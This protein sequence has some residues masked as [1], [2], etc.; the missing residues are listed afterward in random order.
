MDEC[1]HELLLPFRYGMPRG[2]HQAN[3]FDCGNFTVYFIRRWFGSDRPDLSENTTNLKKWFS[4]HDIFNFKYDCRRYLDKLV[5]LADREPVNV[6]GN[7]E[8]NGYFEDFDTALE[9]WERNKAYRKNKSAATH[10]TSY[11]ESQTKS[12]REKINLTSSTTSNVLMPKANQNAES[13]DSVTQ[14]PAA[15]MI[16]Q[17]PKN[18]MKSPPLISKNSCDTTPEVSPFSRES[19]FLTGPI[20]NNQHEDDLYISYPV[21]DKNPA[22][23][24]STRLVTVSSKV[25]KKSTSEKF[26]MKSREKIEVTSG[27]SDKSFK[28]DNIT[29]NIVTYEELDKAIK[30]VNTAS[31]IFIPTKNYQEQ[32]SELFSSFERK[33]FCDKNS[34]NTCVS[35]KFKRSRNARNFKSSKY[36]II[37]TATFLSRN[38]LQKYH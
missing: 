21:E 27:S 24:P 8:E 36:K 14:D 23:K 20:D 11:K 30:N 17:R 5:G 7:P 35:L 10:I 4:L 33:E 28:N 38:R 25:S 12:K 13:T 37:K 2:P 22:R 16:I 26:S 29:K 3:D 1:F 18:S 34:K 19:Q 6:E 32:D 15:V 9:Y 31:S